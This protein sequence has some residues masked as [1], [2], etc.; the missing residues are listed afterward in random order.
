MS[1]LTLVESP[2][3]TT[4]TLNNTV[5]SDMPIDEF[6]VLTFLNP[7]NVVT[8]ALYGAAVVRGHPAHDVATL[9]VKVP[10]GGTSY[11]FFINAK[12]STSPTIFNGE[13]RIKRSSFNTN[14]TESDMTEVVALKEGVLITVGPQTFITSQAESAL[15]TF[16]LQFRQAIAT[17]SAD[18]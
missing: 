17:V 15:I 4:L 11:A 12:N 16:T 18:V 8:N 1:Q 14:G 5:I 7:I 13:L 3:G 10:I 9:E 2:E 6:L